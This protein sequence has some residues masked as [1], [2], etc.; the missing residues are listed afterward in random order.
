MN[1]RIGFGRINVEFRL[2]RERRRV[3]STPKQKR[4][5]R[6]ATI[7]TII[8][9]FCSDKMSALPG[10]ICNARRRF[11]EARF[12]HRVGSLSTFA[13]Y[14]PKRNTNLRR[15][16]SLHSA[17]TSNST[18]RSTTAPGAIFAGVRT[19]GGLIWRRRI[20]LPRTPSSSCSTASSA[21]QLAR[22]STTTRSPPSSHCVSRPSNFLQ[23][24]AC[25][26]CRR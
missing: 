9:S 7:S 26:C 19:L 13:Y 5:Y 1:A 8:A 23:I 24:H 2:V 3:F 14:L 21:K 12:N 4:P 18:I 15:S 11:Y 16:S 6:A 25:A 20:V 17:G 10:I 22:V